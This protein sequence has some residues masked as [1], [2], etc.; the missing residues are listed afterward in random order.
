MSPVFL[1]PNVRLP[2][3]KCPHCRMWLPVESLSL[4][5]YFQC[6]ECYAGLRI[7]RYYRIVATVLSAATSVVVCVLSG[8][9]LWGFVILL[10]I[11]SLV[12]YPPTSLVLLRFCP[13]RI[14]DGSPEGFSLFGS[15]RQ[16][17]V[18]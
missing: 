1:N 14:R 7:S 6:P 12:F 3:L 4:L 8:V 10:S 5:E 16:D 9:S 15:R 11:F 2:F 18:E 13:P 17:P